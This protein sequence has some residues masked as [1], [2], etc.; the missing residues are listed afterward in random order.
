LNDQTQGTVLNNKQYDTAKFLTVIVLPALGTLY[1]A[2]AQIWGL[3]AGE[4]ILGSVLAVEACIGAVLG[5]SAKQYQESG[6]K[7]AGQINVTDTP[8]KTTFD[9]ELKDEPEDLINKDEV[10]FKVNTP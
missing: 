5:I 3:P 2:L 10:T 9:L 8:Q 7:Y 4:Q 1:F 6:A